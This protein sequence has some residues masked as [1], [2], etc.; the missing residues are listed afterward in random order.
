MGE[1]TVGGLSRLKGK[2]ARRKRIGP[3]SSPQKSRW[4]RGNDAVKWDFIRI[5]L[6][7]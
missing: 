3:S 2:R 5:N 6:Q 4:N 1:W 7:L